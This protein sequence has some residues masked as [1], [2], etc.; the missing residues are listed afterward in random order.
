MGSTDAKA[1]LASLE[2]VAA[3]ASSGKISGPGRYQE[4]EVWRGVEFGEGDGIQEADRMITTDRT[5]EKIIDQLDS[6]VANAEKDFDIETETT[7]QKDEEKLV[8]ILSGFPEKITGEIVFCDAD[9]INTDGIYPGKLTYQDYVPVEQMAEACMQNY[10]PA[11]SSVAKKGD[12]LVSGFSFGCGSS[13]EQAAT[14][15][16]AKGILLCRFRINNA[17]IAL[18]VPKLVERLRQSFPVPSVHQKQD[19][20]GSSQSKESFDSSSHA[21]LKETPRVLTWRTCW[22]LNWDVRRSKVEIDEGEGKPKW[23]VKVSEL[24]ANVQEII[25]RGG[26]KK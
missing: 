6:T 5:L 3:R 24:P 25:V 22:S 18:E 15:I 17:L 13:R 2:V 12:I 21:P 8:S 16:L 7:T 20:T 19:V 26:S 1:Y 14:A 9:N 10:D 11:I 23:S 4:L